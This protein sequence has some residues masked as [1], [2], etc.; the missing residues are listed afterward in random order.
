MIGQM[1]GPYQILSKVGEGGMGEVYKARDTRLDR[2]VAIKVLPDAF[3]RDADRL[4][5][6]EREARAVAAIS[7]PNILAIHDV[8]SDNGRTFVVTELLDGE[9]LRA[10]LNRGALPV[11]KAIEIGI[12]IARGLAAAHDKGIVH[13]D[14]KPENVFLLADGQVKI[15]DFGLAKA[16]AAPGAGSGASETAAAATD[17]GTVL[18]TAGYMAPEQVR[19][20]ATD[21][22]ADLFAFGAV[23]YEMVGGARAFKGD[24]AADTM[25][26][27]LREDPPDLVESRPDLPPALDRIVRH[28]LEKNPAERFQSARDVAFSLEALSGS[29]TGP[30]ARPAP[31]RGAASSKRRWIASGF[32]GGFVMASAALAAWWFAAGPAQPAGPCGGAPR[33]WPSAGWRRSRREKAWRSIRR[34]PP[35]A[36]CSPTPRE[37]PG[38]CA[39]MS[40]RCRRPGHSALR[41]R[42]RVRVPAPLVAGR[43]PDPVPDAGRGSSGALAGGRVAEDCRRRRQRRGLGARRCPDP[44]RSAG[45]RCRLRRSKAAR[46]ARSGTRLRSPTSATGPAKAT[47]SHVRLATGSA[48]RPDSLSATSRRAASL[49]GRAYRRSLRRTRRAPGA[50][51]EPRLVAR[52]ADAVLRVEPRGL[53]R[54]LRAW[55]RGRRAGQR[56]AVPRDDRARRPGHLARGRRD[57]PRVRGLR[58][59]QQHLVGAD[60]VNRHRRRVGCDARHER[61]P[62]CRGHEGLPRWALAAVRL[63]AVRQF[64]DLQGSRVRRTGRA[65]D[66]RSR[67]RF[68]AGPLAGRPSGGVPQ[69]PPGRARRLR[70]ERRGR[71]GAAGRP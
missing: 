33:R 36:S 48:S 61:E 10:R 54:H 25:T 9:T 31:G 8:G 63:H 24:T 13:R 40:A 21:A 70:P 59:A 27:I 32:A 23:L 12:Q 69:L 5:R 7:H 52:R 71:R 65:V 47:A 14:L 4:A 49:I 56:R 57:A 44:R 35:T 42:R 16:A 39:S 58:R 34:F 46:S 3:A 26:A 45:L 11:R 19:G 37:P 18:G 20:Q 43:K 50:E 22:R 38:A 17:P 55:R 1:L 51:S 62:D 28:C 15:L 30:H 6:F 29:G 2:T 66:D 68:R 41:R 53:A 67:R 60:T 64:G